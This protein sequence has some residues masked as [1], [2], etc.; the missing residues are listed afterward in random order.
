MQRFQVD[1]EQRSARF[2]SLA[3]LLAN[4]QKIAAASLRNLGGHESST[5]SGHIEAQITA[6]HAANGRLAHHMCSVER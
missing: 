2:L 6:R 3:T 4:L 5:G 1:S